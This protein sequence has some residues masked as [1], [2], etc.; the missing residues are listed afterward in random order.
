M[1]TEKE[2]PAYRDKTVCKGKTAYKKKAARIVKRFVAIIIVIAMILGLSRG[3]RYILVDDAGSYTR[4]T[5]HEFYEQ[6]NIDELFVGASHCYNGL[7]P[8]VFDER[9]GKNTFNAGSALQLMNVSYTLIQEAVERYDVEHIYLEVSYS[10]A[11][12]NKWGGDSIL[13][14]IYTIADY[15]KPSVKKARLLTTASGPEYYVNNFFPARR[16]WDKLFDPEYIAKVLK[17]KGKDKYKN[18]EPVFDYVGKGHISKD[19][20]VEENSYFTGR[21]YAEIKDEDFSAEWEENLL[22]IIEYCKSKDVKLTLLAAPYPTYRLAGFGN[23]DK[24]IEKVNSVIE[25]TGIKFYDFNLC[26]EKYLPDTSTL[27][28]DYTHLNRQGAEIFSNLVA[29]LMAGEITEEE[30]FYESCAEKLASLEPNVYGLCY[31][32]FTDSETNESF[33]RVKVASNRYEGIEFRIQITPEEGEPYL[34]RDFSEKRYFEISPEEHGVCTVAWR[35]IDN[36]EYVK[37]VSIS[38]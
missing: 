5:M 19:N 29:D 32:V 26:R 22:Q 34:V 33:R 15:L 8:Y 18:Y 36:P 37:E 30:L 25:G 20:S 7:N 23:Y 13:T 9:S 38:F 21:S 11:H 12:K 10:V 16:N 14:S 17:K 1:Q 24:Y 28:F 4:L 27:F 3:L 2:Q 31:K 35:M 6:E